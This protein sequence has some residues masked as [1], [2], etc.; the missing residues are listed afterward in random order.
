MT[1]LNELALGEAI[2]N[3]IRRKWRLPERWSMADTDRMELPD[4]LRDRIDLLGIDDQLLLDV[5][6]SHVL[7]QLETLER[8]TAEEDTGRA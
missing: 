3:Y 1:D 8:L 2:Q 6:P 5:A 4:M 7:K